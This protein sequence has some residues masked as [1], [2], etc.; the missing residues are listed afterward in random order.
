MQEEYAAFLD[1]EYNLIAWSFRD[2]DPLRNNK[3]D[4]HYDCTQ[5]QTAQR[6]RLDLLKTCR[7]V[8]NEATPILWYNSIF[9][10]ESA[11]TARK[12]MQERTAAQKGLVK[13]LRFN[14]HVPNDFGPYGWST[15][16][17]STFVTTLPALRTLHLVIDVC[18]GESYDDL[19]CE[20]M[21]QEMRSRCQELK[22]T[23]RPLQ[24]APL[25][26]VTARISH[27]RQRHADDKDYLRGMGYHWPLQDCVSY[28]EDL[29]EYLKAPRP[30]KA[31]GHA[32][33][34]S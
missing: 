11:Y 3:N 15:L 22:R 17:D 4:H 33:V 7:R 19:T 32:L 27:S 25:K 5:N 1:T 26:E 29:A 31:P 8:Y 18:W 24:E 13:Q 9:S 12:F 10:F 14:M 34:Q 28:A 2:Q 30:S 23:L 20:Y 6:V 16:L 21:Q